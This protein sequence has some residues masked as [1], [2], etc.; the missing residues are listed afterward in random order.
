MQQ[1]LLDAGAQIVAHRTVSDDKSQIMQAY[2]SLMS[3][4]TAQVV[5]ST[6]GTGLS[7]RDVTP[8]ALM[9]SCDRLIPGFGELLRSK[10]AEHV[11]DLLA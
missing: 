6:G 10:G 1:L 7:P 5:L 8:E 2:H 11:E 9:A 4:T 3:E